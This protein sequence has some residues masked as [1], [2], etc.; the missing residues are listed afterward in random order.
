M[1]SA[2]TRSPT[3]PEKPRIRRRSAV[4]KADPPGGRRSGV[5]RPVWR[6]AERREVSVDMRQYL[7]SR[8]IDGMRFAVV[9]KRLPVRGA[10]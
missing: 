5:C 2:M 9:V 8:Q 3:A 6:K 1:G 10:S 4:A 7:P